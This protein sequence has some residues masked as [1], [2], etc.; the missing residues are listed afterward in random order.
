MYV[1]HAHA[2]FSVV[3]FHHTSHR[4]LQQKHLWSVLMGMCSS[5]F[6]HYTNWSYMHPLFVQ[7]VKKKFTMNSAFCVV[8]S[9]HAQW[10]STNL[11]FFYFSLF[12]DSLHH[13][14]SPRQPTYSGHPLLHGHHPNGL[15]ELRCSP[16]TPVVI[17]TSIACI[18]CVLLCQSNQTW[19]VPYF[20]SATGWFEI[21][22]NS[23]LVWLAQEVMKVEGM[24]C[25]RLS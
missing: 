13:I 14:H 7:Q 21:R 6:L 4:V 10:D 3:D 1:P 8:H 18:V 15:S 20:K 19:T 5:C 24:A 9:S 11:F 17:E 22:N 2:P 16:A 25:P 23:S 12:L